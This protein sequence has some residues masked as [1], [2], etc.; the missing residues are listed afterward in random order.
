MYNSPVEQSLVDDAR[1]A[2]EYGLSSVPISTEFSF[3]DQRMPVQA[4]RPP[5]HHQSWFGVPSQPQPFFNR[6]FSAPQQPTNEMA[7]AM[8][9]QHQQNWARQQQQQP[10]QFEQVRTNPL[11][12]PYQFDMF[13]TL[14]DLSP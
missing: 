6:T 14:S 5:A 2:Y 13:R 11:G 7:A 9:M 1:A 10:Q 3:V 8:L 12:V 4:A